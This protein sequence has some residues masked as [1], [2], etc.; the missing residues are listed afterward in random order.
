MGRLWRVTISTLVT[1]GLLAASMTGATPAAA[2]P[3]DAPDP[4]R[5]KSTPVRSVSPR[6]KV[7]KAPSETQV[8][9]PRWPARQQAS[10]EP[11]SASRKHRAGDAPVRVGVAKGGKSTTPVQVT[12]AGADASESAVGLGVVFSVA[13]EPGAKLDLE[14]DYSQ[15]APEVGGGWASRLELFSL[16]DCALT[17][18]ERAECQDRTPLVS[19]NDQKTETLAASVA[20]PAAATPGTTAPSSLVV[21]AAAAASGATGS[22]TATSLQV[23]STWSSGTSSGTFNW[24]MP[25]R[26]APVPGDLTPEL[27]LSYSSG[28][29][30]GKT[31][32]E[33]AQASWVGEGFDLSAGFIER[34]YISCGDDKSGGNNSATTGDLCFFTDSKKNN[35]EKW[36]NASLSFGNHSGELVRIGNTAQWRLQNDDG[37]RVTKLGGLSDEHWE[38]T[39]TDGTKYYFGKGKAHA[40]SAA[41]N[42]RWA[43]P[44]AGNQTGEPGY[45]SKFADSFASRTWRWNLDYVV[46]PT[47]DTMT[48]YYAKETNYYKKN[49]STKT[50]YDRGGYLNRIQYGERAGSEGT[51]PAAQVDFVVK[52]RCIVGGKVTNCETATPTAATAGNWPD[53]PVDVI[54]ASTSCSTATTSPTFFTRKRLTQINT[55]VKNASNTYDAIDTWDLTQ[56]WPSGS[57]T[58]MPA[59][60]LGQIRQ[61]GKA[62]TAIQMPAIT[63]TPVVL[64]NRVASAS[65]GELF[66]KPRMSQ[67]KT[68]TGSLIWVNY[69]P[70]ECSSSSLPTP[71]TNTK[72]CF[73]SYFS[74]TGATTPTR[75]WFHKYVVDSVVVQ[76]TAQQTDPNPVNGFDLSSQVVTKYS[77]SGGGA[78]HYNDSPLIKP[79]HRTWGDWR[80]FQTVT[81]IEGNAGYPQAVEET[82]Y[83]RGMNG[84]RLNSGGGTK[85]VQVLGRN[86]DDELNG[87]VRRTR[88]LDGVGGAET[89][90]TTS[91]PWVGPITANDGRTKARALRE[92][93]SRGTFKL[94]NGSQREIKTRTISWDAYGQPLEVENAGDL[95]TP[96]DDTC[97][98]NTYA[99]NTTAWVLDKIS[100]TS[101]MPGL[102]S[103]PLDQSKVLSWIRNYFDGSSTLGSVTKGLQTK[104]AGLQDG[105]SGRAWVTTSTMTYDQF[106]RVLTNTDAIGSTT[107]TAYTPATSSP[108]R[109][110]AVTS[111]DP[112]GS[113]PNPKQTTTTTYDPRWGLV[114][115]NVE[116][117]GQTSESELDALGRVTKVWL[118]GRAR[119]DT[120]SAKYAYT[121]NSSG[122]NAVKTETLR[123]DGSYSTSYEISDSLLR[124]RQKQTQAPNTGRIIDDT[125]YNSRGQAVVTDHYYN[126]S[127][128]SLA[129]VQPVSATEIPSSTRTK[130]DSQGRPTATIFAAYGTE[131]WRTST[132]YNGEKVKVT[133]PGGGTPTTTTSDAQ[134]HV[135]ERIDHLG[136]DTTAP[137]V[138][139][140]FGYTAGAGLRAWM[141]D[142][143]GNTWRFSYDMQGNTVRTEDPDKGVSTSTYDVMGRLASMTDARGK[144][145]VYSYD[146]LG[147]V[148][149]TA[150]LDGATLTTATYDNLSDGTTKPGV[151]AS[152]SRHASGGQ[153]TA[154]T[155]SVNAAGRPT[156][157]TT[158]I[159]AISN[160]ISSQLAGSYSTTTAY[161]PDGTVKSAQLPAMGGIGAE[162]LTYGYTARGDDYTLT[163]TIG[164]TASTYVTSTR[165]RD[166]GGVSMMTLGSVTGRNAYVNYLRDNSTDRL[167][168]IRLDRQGVTGAADISTLSYDDAGNVLKVASDLPGSDDDTQCFV[169][170]YQRQLTEAWTPA[171]GDCAAARSQAGLG[172][173]AAYW[174]SW[175][176]D[177]IGRTSK[178][179]DRTATSSA[180]TT[181]SY[182]AA[183]QPKPHFVTGTSTVSSSGTVSSSYG[184]DAAGNTT[185][186]PVAGGGSQALAWS[187]EGKLASV[188]V[189]GTVS[190]QM[191]YDAAGARVLRK[192]G[193]TTTLYVGDTE[194][195]QNG[196]G[197]VT[198][199]RYYSLADQPVAMRSGNAAAD[200]Q[201][202]VADHQGTIRH[203]VNHS[204]GVLA[205]TW[206]DPFGNPRG[207]AG[208]GWAGERAFVGGTKDASG[209]IHVGAREYDPQLNRFISVDP[210][211]DM[212]DPLSWNAYVYANNSPVTFSDPTGEWIG[213]WRFDLG[214]SGTKPKPKKPSSRHHAPKAPPRYHPGSSYV[215]PPS[216]PSP[217]PAGTGQHGPT[218]SPPANPLA[219][220]IGGFVNG[221]VDSVADT[222][223]QAARGAGLLAQATPWG[224]QVNQ[225]VDN[226]E[227]QYQATTRSIATSM[228]LNP[229][230]AAYGAGK[231]TGEIAAMAIPGG[232]VLKV[233]SK[234]AKLAKGAKTD[235]LAGVACR[236]NSFD[237]D[238]PV[239]MA[240]GAHKPIADIAVGDS[241]WASDPDTGVAG[242]RPVTDLIRHGGPHLMIDIDFTDGSQVDATDRHPFWNVDREAWV[243]A[244]S[245]HP[246]DTVLTAQGATLT[247]RHTRITTRTL[248]AYNLTV[249][250]LHTYHVTNSDILVHNCGTRPPNLTPPGGGRSAAFKQAKRDSG[251][252]TSMSPNRTTVNVDRRGNRQPGRVYE[253]DVPASGGG[254]RTVRIRD[255]SAG[256]NFG[257]SDPQNRGPH[258]NTE[259]GGHY[260]Y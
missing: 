248:T 129:L 100:E 31:A 118:P 74:E 47:N 96:D 186:R 105:A 57:D 101:V 14:L 195:E 110:I 143:Q 75:Q 72:R 242:P 29:S 107:T 162:T 109:S 246:G 1:A 184:F 108:L 33:N 216:G 170:D 236:I 160:L 177:T 213:G 132:E 24:S 73:P 36:D 20:L 88:S 48:Y 215:P 128:P 158:T 235:N 157:Q 171:A 244:I 148:T 39:T 256:H 131:K 198:A 83:F 243:D 51:S 95:S 91:D 4:Q 54:C 116:P 97:T 152:S 182:P 165:Y 254:T 134:G 175:T 142:A 32:S 28:A 98:R 225:F 79:K 113:G 21:A 76:D 52:E 204:T 232:A 103:V 210:V 44:V 122:F 217:A 133:P 172:G 231:I 224:H 196:T 126:A 154:S 221:L 135:V 194:L 77:Y 257:P 41:T 141:K 174:T 123:F 140:T 168:T 153:L 6:E 94:A 90:T 16:P 23:S 245:L 63:L 197:A 156:K 37:T 2:K 81:T 173:P 26:V 19:R 46:S 260:D 7:R 80:G 206:T 230:S 185:A 207:T 146:K 11:L 70:Q 34:T 164:G 85:S 226:A 187:V 45:K 223:F 180:T 5:V 167:T 229:D 99:V 183:G 10:T 192:Q 144:G 119:T 30:D 238:T 86:D 40:S 205:T 178:R 239:L 222:V 69:L 27:T 60:W 241:V 15:F 66:G 147:R 228:G 115:K 150:D 220:F 9:A 200:V 149:K 22:F 104:A 3:W 138:K 84:D 252:P 161:H 112:D 145:V 18:P 188:T 50:I 93:E 124:V 38:V 199:R 61:T 82:T 201:S 249:A 130:I 155:D 25:L 211:Q 64:D 233:A 227:K 253:F 58:S 65:S 166:L 102:C 42:S 181:L 106:G 247:V 212:D 78:W 137:G 121:L 163:G 234:A 237:D 258:F 12:M 59:M 125:R 209:L 203:Q 139:T 53:V 43:V 117:A 68:E 87:T 208:T 120:P 255:D 240:D 13:G 62:G 191:L 151:Q 35:D 127:E 259:N 169:Y 219:N 179:V 250:D 251:V 89:T 49:L 218:N 114:V 214:G 193:S 56:S 190:A 159:P 189:G 111:D 202:L 136:A 55:K 92:G 8:R 67:I 17:T 71:E 176:H